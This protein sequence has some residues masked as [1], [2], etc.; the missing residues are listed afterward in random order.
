MLRVGIISIG[1]G[2]LAENLLH[3]FAFAWLPLR[4]LVGQWC[5]RQPIQLENW[6]KIFFVE[7]KSMEQPSAVHNGI[8]QYSVKLA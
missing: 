1:L 8:L 3:L 6:R 5:T 7:L 2:K 4:L